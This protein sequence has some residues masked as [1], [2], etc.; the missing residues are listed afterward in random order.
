MIGGDVVQLENGQTE[1]ILAFNINESILG[2]ETYAV[3]STPQK[4]TALRNAFTI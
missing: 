2:E 4:Q 3:T 1:G